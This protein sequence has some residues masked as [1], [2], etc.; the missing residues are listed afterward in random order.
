MGYDNRFGHEDSSFSFSF[1]LSLTRIPKFGRVFMAASRARI[2]AVEGI[3]DV[4]VAAIAAFF[5]K[6]AVY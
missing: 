5:P 6:H 4:T 1:S 2:T 3:M